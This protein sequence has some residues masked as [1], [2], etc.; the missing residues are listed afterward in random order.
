MYTA[1]F[2]HT[3]IQVISESAMKPH[4]VLFGIVYI[5][6]HLWIMQPETTLALILFMPEF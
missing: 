4:Q 5:S 1:K 3:Q 2:I 6:I